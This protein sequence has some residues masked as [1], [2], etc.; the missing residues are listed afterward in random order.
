MAIG[1]VAVA[2]LLRMVNP[3][4]AVPDSLAPIVTV[5]FW[6]ASIAL[7]VILYFEG[8]DPRADEVEVEGPAFARFLFNNSR[9]G[10]FWLPIRLFVGFEWLEAGTRT[11]S[12]HDR[13]PHLCSRI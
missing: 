12:V 5:A 8:R 9:A 11:H 2:L 7:V 1:P 6:I 10:L 3:W 4:V 13:I